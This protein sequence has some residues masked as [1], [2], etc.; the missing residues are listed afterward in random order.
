MYIIHVCLK[1][2]VIPNEMFPKTPLPNAAFAS[3]FAN[4]R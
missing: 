2:R 4:L 1:I 3:M